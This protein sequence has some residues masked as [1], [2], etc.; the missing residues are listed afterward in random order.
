MTEAAVVATPEVNNVL[1]QHVVEQPSWYDVLAEAVREPGFVS[2]AYKFYDRYSMSNRVLAAA[3]LK[4]LK[5]PLQP[6]NTF[7]GWKKLN[8]RVNEGEKAAIYLNQ[9]AP[10]KKV[11]TDELGNESEVVT[12]TR[13]FLA[14]KW[15]V[16]AQTSGEDFIKQEV[17]KND[18]E[19]TL[20][21]AMA[22]LDI[23]EVAF[24]F[25]SISDTRPGFAQAR[26]FGISP[27]E[28]HPLFGRI[29]QCAH[30]LLGH[31]ADVPNKNVPPEPELREVEAEAVAYL[32]AA[33]L[34][35]EGLEESR[36]TMQRLLTEFGKEKIPDRLA[37]RAFG[38]ADK[39]INEGY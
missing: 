26:S 11:V 2:Q 39:L 28:N 27:L 8:R 19:W 22:S 32:V 12:F 9:P 13:F 7:N 34:G 15:F 30:I 6:I 36:G 35:I 1:I 38:M 5:L 31:T 23:T 16:L 4:W 29:R 33:T 25:E 37:H 20:A 3:Q 21:N 14:R 24:E 10:S 17:A 18:K